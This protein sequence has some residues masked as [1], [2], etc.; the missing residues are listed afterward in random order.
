[1]KK[2]IIMVLVLILITT[3]LVGCGGSKLKD[4]TY[5][6]EGT[7]METIKVSVEVKEGKIASVEI[8]E[9]EESEG[10]SEPAI[11]QLPGIIVD[12]NSTDVDAISGATVTSDGIKEAVNNALEK[13]K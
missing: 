7:G 2:S 12:K 3:S 1:M 9:H 11:E 6:G 10:Y 5:A 8:T 4:G 13:A